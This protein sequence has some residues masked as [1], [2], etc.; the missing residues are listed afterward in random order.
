MLMVEIREQEEIYAQLT[1]KMTKNLSTY[2]RYGTLLRGNK[3]M[4]QQ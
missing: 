1:Y 3:L 4:V 2:V